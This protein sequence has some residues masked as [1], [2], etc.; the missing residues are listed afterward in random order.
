LA[1][2]GS[3]EGGGIGDGE[4]GVGWAKAG[5]PTQQ[6]IAIAMQVRNSFIAMFVS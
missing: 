5:K 4:E 1:Q 6:S 2:P 3:S